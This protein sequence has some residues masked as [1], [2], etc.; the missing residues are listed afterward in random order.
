MDVEKLKDGNGI[1]I[2]ENV[3]VATYKFGRD[4]SFEEDMQEMLNK[5]NTG[6]YEP[7]MKYMMDSLVVFENYLRQHERTPTQ[8]IRFINNYK[9][10]PQKG[11]YIGR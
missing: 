3:P 6:K 1:D 8:L 2:L 9:S 5:Y 4:S 7:Y 10:T 11:T